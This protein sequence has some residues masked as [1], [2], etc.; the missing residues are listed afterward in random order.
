VTQEI[1]VTVI[2]PTIPGREILLEECKESVR[3]QTMRPKD[4]L[5]GVDVD[6]RGPAAMRNS[7]VEKVKTEWVAFLDDDDLL[8]PNHFAT[9]CWYMDR[10]IDT[11]ATCSASMGGGIVESAANGADRQYDV[12]STWAMIIHGPDN[13]VLFDVAPHVDRIMSNH[14]TLP[15]TATVRTSKFREV[16]GF[17]KHVRFEDMV[18]WQ[19]FLKANAS[20]RSIYIPTWYYR[21]QP[22]GRNSV[23]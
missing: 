9:H 15:V 4:H 1:D 16:G 22:N 14:N 20:F 3:K 7:L 2:T 10:P 5:I 13:E 11:P 19:D 23:E 8:M 18:L 17:K 6:G 12:I 21:L